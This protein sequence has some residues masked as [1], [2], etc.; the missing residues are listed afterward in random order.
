MV[1]NPDILIYADM[2]RWEIQQRMR[3]SSVMGMGV[4]NHQEPFRYS[5][6]GYFI[7][8]PAL[9]NYKRESLKGLTTGL[10]RL[11]KIH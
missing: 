7:D 1:A 8:W 2:P 6:R 5:L 11:R 10:S 9:D 3:K 4:D